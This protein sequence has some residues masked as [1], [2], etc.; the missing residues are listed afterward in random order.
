M[1]AANTIGSAVTID[2]QL[3]HSKLSL[4]PGE[5]ALQTN[6]PPSSAANST[7][8]ENH[9]MATTSNNSTDMQSPPVSPDLFPSGCS[10]RITKYTVP[11]EISNQIVYIYLLACKH[12]MYTRRRRKLG[13]QYNASKTYVRVAGASSTDVRFALGRAAGGRR[14]RG[15]RRLREDYGSHPP[16][17]LRQNEATNFNIRDESAQTRNTLPK[18]K[19]LTGNMTWTRASYRVLWLGFRF[20]SKCIYFLELFINKVTIVQN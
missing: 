14:R 20:N 7:G 17:R 9:S 11:K 5:R 3:L 19:L 4:W 18:R 12:K 6:A 2:P 1:R 16:N 10:V 15:G 13:A 8:T